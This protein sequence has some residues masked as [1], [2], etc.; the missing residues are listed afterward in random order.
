VSA[1]PPSAASFLHTSWWIPILIVWVLA[2]FFHHLYFRKLPDFLWVFD[3]GI[4]LRPGQGEASTRTRPAFGEW[5]S[6][7]LPEVILKAALLA[8]DWWPWYECS[9]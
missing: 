1:Y 8:A 5:M 2:F 9:S 6:G 4:R 7:T 3:R